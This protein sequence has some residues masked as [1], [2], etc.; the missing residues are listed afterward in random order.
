MG[1][2]SMKAMDIACS[3]TF[4]DL[5]NIY[6]VDDSD[7]RAILGKLLEKLNLVPT[8]TTYFRKGTEMV[9][10]ELE[11]IITDEWGN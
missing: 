5:T 4:F 8:K 6:E 3:K 10:Y 1:G 7:I 9:S 11:P 2:R